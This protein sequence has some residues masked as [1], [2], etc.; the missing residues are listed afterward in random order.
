[1][2]NNEFHTVIVYKIARIAAFEKDAMAATLGNFASPFWL[3]IGYLARSFD[4]R[5]LFFAFLFLARFLTTAGIGYLTLGLSGRSAATR[6][7]M[8]A[9]MATLSAGFL[10]GLPLGADPAMDTF[11]SQTFFSYGLCLLALGALFDGKNLT[12]AAVLGVAYYVN[13][14]QANFVL[15]IACAHFLLQI[16]RREPGGIV[17]SLRYLGV[18]VVIASP[19]IVWSYSVISRSSPGDFLA[20][21]ALVDFARFYYPGHYFFLGKPLMTKKVQGL[22]LALLPLAMSFSRGARIQNS[23]RL[24][25]IILL[26]YIAAE[27][28]F[29]HVGAT[30]LFFQ[31]HLLRSDVISYALAVATAC[32][33]VANLAYEQNQNWAL[34]FIVLAVILHGEYRGALFVAL[35]AVTVEH[36]KERR[37]YIWGIGEK[38]AAM[39]MVLGIAALSVL[40]PY[41]KLIPAL[42]AAPILVLLKNWRRLS[43]GLYVVLVIGVTVLLAKDVVRKRDYLV[44][45]RYTRVEF[46]RFCQAASSILPHDAL[47][48]VPPSLKVRACLKRSIYVNWKEGAAYL[49]NKGFEVSYLRRLGNIGVHYTPGVRLSLESSDSTYMRSFRGN[50]ALLKRDGVTHAI[51]DKN[52]SAELGAHVLLFSG[53]YCLIGL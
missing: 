35:F 5:V 32:A 29:D 50:A 7:W 21:K 45:S 12:S 33:L 8:L 36:L 20:G 30:R 37:E 3:L 16:L 10:R 39:C 9:M 11:L 23:L 25:S 2:D 40:R 44:Q 51:I 53:Q 34:Y 13:L 14:M 27:A 47:V 4:P 26:S 17:K 18:F 48:A 49:W 28:A 31:L 52:T 15:G 43:A 38:T 22:A 24:T 42:A 46:D 41:N 6:S 1:I 19:M